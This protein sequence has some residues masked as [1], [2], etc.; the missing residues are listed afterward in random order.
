MLAPTLRAQFGVS[1][2]DIGDRISWGEARDL[3]L[4]AAADTSTEFGAS[5]AGWA[6]PASLIELMQLSATIADNKAFQSA[7]PWTMG[8][9]LRRRAAEQATPDEIAVLD[10]QLD[11][12]IV[13]S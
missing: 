8:E 2:D 12:E 6:Y 3:V 7:A 4:S 11:E 1:I 13:F 10:A 5:L 9:E